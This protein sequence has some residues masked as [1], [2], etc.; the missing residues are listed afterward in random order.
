[1]GESLDIKTSINGDVIG[2]VAVAAT[3]PDALVRVGTDKT[4]E[5]FKQF[6][7]YQERFD[8]NFKDEFYIMELIKLKEQ[9]KATPNEHIRTKK[10]LMWL[11]LDLE[12]SIKLREKP[13]I[14]QAFDNYKILIAVTNITDIEDI[15]L[16]GLFPNNGNTVKYTKMSRNKIFVELF[17]GIIIEIIII[18]KRTDGTFNVDIG[19][20]MKCN[21]Y[22]NLTND[23]VV[24]EWLKTTIKPT[25]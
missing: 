21:K 19:R 8:I 9:Y 11:I 3:N 14:E 24:E 1:M 25:F 10:D 22:I 4:E 23:S 2:K 6:K 12:K 20:G 17:T 16:K 18:P 5:I 13:V 15:M 7:Q